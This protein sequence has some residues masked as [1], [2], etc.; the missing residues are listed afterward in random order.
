MSMIRN[1]LIY[2]SE[3]RYSELSHS[4]HLNDVGYA[5][6]NSSKILVRVQS[7]F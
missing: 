7:A 3:S 2:I 6:G 1:I 4:V 5:S